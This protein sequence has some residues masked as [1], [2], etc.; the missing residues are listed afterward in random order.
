MWLKRPLSVNTSCSDNWDKK[1]WVYARNKRL[2]EVQQTAHR[3]SVPP[4]KNSTWSPQSSLVG[5]VT[6]FDHNFSTPSFGRASIFSRDSYTSNPSGLPADTTTME[7]CFDRFVISTSFSKTHASRRRSC[8]LSVS[9]FS[10]SSWLAEQ[11]RCRLV[12]GH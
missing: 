2:R 6:S 10:A 1:Q 4:I 7:R 8:C 11:L 12:F 3:R 5:F 9:H